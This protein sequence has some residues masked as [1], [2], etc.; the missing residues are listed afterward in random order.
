MLS[1]ISLSRVS[2]PLVPVTSPRVADR[3]GPRVKMGVSGERREYCWRYGGLRSRHCG[4]LLRGQ[5]LT[6]GC[7]LQLDAV[8]RAR[9]TF[10]P[11]TPSFSCM[12]VLIVMPSTFSLVF[13]LLFP[14]PPLPPPLLKGPTE[15]IRSGSFGCHPLNVS[16]FGVAGVEAT[17]SFLR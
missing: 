2:F 1:V 12:P 15:L 5:S 10:E 6:H 16:S 11:R 4:L 14:T 9:L 7:A 13:S 8:T 3:S 17:T